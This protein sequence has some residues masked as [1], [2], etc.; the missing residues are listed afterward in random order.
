MEPYLDVE[1]EDQAVPEPT[2]APNPR[3]KWAEKLIE[4]AGNNVGDPSD[5]RRTR[6]QF[7]DENLALCHTYPLLLERHYMMVG[8]YPPFYKEALHD[9]RWQIAMDKE[10]ES[11]QNNKTW[12]LVSLSPGR[13]L[14]HCKWIYKE[15]LGYDG[16]TT[17]Y[18]D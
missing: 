1:Y 10:S 15:K 4:A 3:P 2:L 7:Q 5:Q 13:N 8:S 17:K 6:S 16:Y 18:K 12:D 9:P 11:L 14:V